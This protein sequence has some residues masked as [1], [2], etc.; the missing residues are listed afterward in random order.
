MGVDVVL[1]GPGPEELFLDRARD[2]LLDGVAATPPTLMVSPAA[3]RRLTP[4]KAVRGVADAQVSARAD[5]GASALAGG[6]RSTA[7]TGVRTVIANITGGIDTAVVEAGGVHVA[8]SSPR[9]LSPLDTRLLDLRSTLQY[10]EVRTER[11][12]GQCVASVPRRVAALAVS[13]CILH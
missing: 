4:P 1:A 3:T 12:A 6:W 7:G 2:A 10:A 5:E 11:V 8:G 9:L 13:R